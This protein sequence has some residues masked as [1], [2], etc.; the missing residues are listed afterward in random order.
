MVM[1]N[2]L[3][4]VLKSA[5]FIAPAALANIAPVFSHKILKGKAVPVDLGKKFGRKP[6][7]GSHKTYKGFFAGVITAIIVVFLQ[8]EIYFVDGFKEFSL[9]DYSSI[10]PFF[11]GFLFGFG[12]MFGDLAESFVKRRVGKK[13]GEAFVPW[14]Q[15]DFII[16]A[17]VLTSF[18]YVPPWQVILAALIITL[19]FHILLSLA[20]YYLGLKKDKL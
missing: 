8:K 1:N 3:E 20:A 12:A 7:F 11:L 17:L 16:G 18:V 13:P 15:L 6:L 2:L 5:Y 9:I 10:N 14:D 4:L 19:I